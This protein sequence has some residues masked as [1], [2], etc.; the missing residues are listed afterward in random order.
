MYYIEHLYTICIIKTK[1]QVSVRIREKQQFEN[2]HFLG[3]FITSH[4]IKPE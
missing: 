3:L 2:Y 4:F 1:L